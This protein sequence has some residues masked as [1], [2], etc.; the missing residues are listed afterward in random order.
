M[1]GN[2]IHFKL[3]NRQ[4]YHENLQQ[5]QYRV[6]M[7]CWECVP[8]CKKMWR[9]E[10]ALYVVHDLEKKRKGELLTFTGTPYKHQGKRK[11]LQQVHWGSHI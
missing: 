6:E 1:L 10:A 11:I 2:V 3:L 8:I 7:N 9:K 4:V 5:V